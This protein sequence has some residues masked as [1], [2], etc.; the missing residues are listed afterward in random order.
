MVGLTNVGMLEGR[1]GPGLVGCKVL[2]H[3]VAASPLEGMVDLLDGCLC[4]SGGLGVGAQP[5]EGGTG[6]PCSCLHGPWAKAQ[7]WF[8]PPVVWDWVL[9]VAGCRAWGLGIMLTH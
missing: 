7:S 4:S 3:A 9:G 1:T 5:L 6:S 2:P 8:W